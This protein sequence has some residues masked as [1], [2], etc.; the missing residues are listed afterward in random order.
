MGATTFYV[1]GEG[2]SARQAFE[3]LVEQAQ[4]EHGHGGGTGT[5]AEKDEFALIPAPTF[6]NDGEVEAY[7]EHLINAGDPR[8]D[9]KWGPAG[10]IELPGGGRW[11]FFGWSPC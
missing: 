6:N 8:V 1:V 9:D 4:H 10:A 5:I 3:D 7:A 2:V 11:L